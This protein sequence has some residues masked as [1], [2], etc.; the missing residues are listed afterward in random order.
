MITGRGNLDPDVHCV[1]FAVLLHL[2]VL[3]D[4][5]AATLSDMAAEN[6]SPLLEEKRPM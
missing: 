2:L 3:Q 5:A 6:S 1:A 4:K